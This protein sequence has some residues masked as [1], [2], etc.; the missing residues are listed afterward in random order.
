VKGQSPIC[1][2][3]AGL[4]TSKRLRKSGPA[5]D[6]NHTMS[7]APRTAFVL[8]GGA[9]LGA[10]QVGMVRA[11]YE[12]GV[13]PDLIVGTSVGALNGAFLASRPTRVQTADELAAVWRGIARG[14]IFPLNP[15]TGFFGFFRVRNHLIP[16]RG[17]RQLITDQVEFNRLEDAAIPLHVIATDLVSG[18]E[19]RI[20]QGD[21]LRAVLASAA[22]PG[23]FPPVERDG[24]T[25]ID[26]GVANNTPIADAI[27][28]GA[29]RIYVLPTGNACDL[30]E[31]PHG[32]VATLLHAM[33]LLIMRRLLVE[34][35][36]L[37]DRAELIVLPPPCPLAVTPIDFSHTDE[38][39][40]RGYE[41]S[42]NYLDAAEAGN[43]PVPLPM[44][45]HDHRDRAPLAA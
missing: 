11:L 32:A 13:A 2:Q 42:R 45:M 44:T 14:Q 19:V 17:L 23:V 39:L 40:R 43:A 20:S 34:V 21:T 28:L 35:E 6:A 4:L 8:S 31:P 25:L 15:L 30:A 16:D 22:I 38:L 29:E 37:R 5:T 27:A 33:S 36:L 1:V 10:I 26:G 41:D 9:S 12:R 7:N 3:L 24:R 18:R